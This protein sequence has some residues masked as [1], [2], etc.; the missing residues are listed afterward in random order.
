M[1]ILII[2]WHCQEGWLLQL[3]FRGI[4]GVGIRT[5][6]LGLPFHAYINY[7]TLR[8]TP[9]LK[10]ST[11]TGPR[12]STHRLLLH[13]FFGALVFL[14]QAPNL[15]AHFLRLLS[16]SQGRPT[17]KTKKHQ[18]SSV[19]SCRS[20]RGAPASDLRTTGTVCFLPRH[21]EDG[22]VHRHLGEANGY[23]VRSGVRYRVNGPA[24]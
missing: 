11:N 24:G 23:H 2:L 3:W 14:I 8:T 4:V 1:G 10:T 20:K 17:T 21:V 16:Q 7:S 19:S 9:E 15:H 13:C 5:L 22:Q 12:P 6:K 18:P